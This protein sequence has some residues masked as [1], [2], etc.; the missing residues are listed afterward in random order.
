MSLQDLQKFLACAET[1]VSL[2]NEFKAIGTGLAEDTDE[3][4]V[5]DKYEKFCSLA[6]SKGLTIVEDDFDEWEAQASE[7]QFKEM[8]DGEVELSDAD[9]EAVAGGKG[10]GGNKTTLTVFATSGFLCW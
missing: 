10:G 2:K 5:C 6:A 7:D 4:I 8:L 1:D 3:A 9:M